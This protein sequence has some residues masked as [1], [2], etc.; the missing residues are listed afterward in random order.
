VLAAIPGKAILAGAAP[1]FKCAEA[2]F[3]GTPVPELAR[4]V[5]VRD[6]AV[7]ACGAWLE[8]AMDA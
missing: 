2:L 3:S 7:E 8:A 6:A 4:V 1:A 5:A